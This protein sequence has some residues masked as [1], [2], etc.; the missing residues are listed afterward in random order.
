M[1]SFTHAEIGMKVTIVL[2]MGGIALAAQ[3]NYHVLAGIL[4][5]AVGCSGIVFSTQFV[6]VINRNYSAKYTRRLP[7]LW[8]IGASLAGLASL[9]A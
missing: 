2:F 4:L 7:I 3:E 1:K 6:Q 9:I 8:G 5:M